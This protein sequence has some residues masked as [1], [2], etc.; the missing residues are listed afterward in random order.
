MDT[1]RMEGCDYPVYVQSRGVCRAHYD[2][3]K[4]VGE[5]PKRPTKA[6]TCSVEDCSRPP[7]F[8]EYCEPHY[9]RWMRTGNPIRQSLSTRFWKFVPY[10]PDDECWPWAGATF[11]N[12]RYGSFKMN[13]SHVMAHRMA[14]E[15]SVGPIPEELTIDHLCRNT[16]CMNPAHLEPVTLKENILRGGNMAANYA[17]RTECHICGGELVFKAERGPHGAR[18]CMTCQN[19][20]STKARLKARG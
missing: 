7:L 10:Q 8:K 11:G 18:V 19:R 15:L 9:R 16:L 13:G 3:M 2:H 4:R 14:Y 20:R 6:A 1:C 17:R 5:I 12:G